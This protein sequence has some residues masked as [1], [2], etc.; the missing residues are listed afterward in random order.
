MLNFQGKY[1]Q[2]SHLNIE[3][4]VLLIEYLSSLND[5]G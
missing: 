3:C 1:W 5:H 4:W 2:R